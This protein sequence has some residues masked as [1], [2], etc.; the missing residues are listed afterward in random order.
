MPN[1]TGRE[2]RQL[3]GRTEKGEKRSFSRGPASQGTKLTLEAHKL[4]AFGAQDMVLPGCRLECGG[5]VD[6]LWEWFSEL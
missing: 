2:M 1:K 3:S 4:P 5:L 6:L